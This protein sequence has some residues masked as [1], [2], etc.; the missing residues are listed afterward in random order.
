MYSY[1][2]IRDYYVSENN[3]YLGK[4]DFYHFVDGEPVD[5]KEI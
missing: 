4:V 5:F 1:A 2:V 3:A